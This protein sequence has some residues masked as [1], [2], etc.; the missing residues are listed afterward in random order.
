MISA[1]RAAKGDVLWQ[2]HVTKSGDQQW[3]AVPPPARP[4]PKRSG[5]RGLHRKVQLLRHR[6]C[7]ARI[8]A[9]ASE[10]L[11]L[12]SVNG[13]DR[14]KVVAVLVAGS[15]MLHGRMDQALYAAACQGAAVKWWLLLLRR[16][17]VPR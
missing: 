15:S 7:L 12:N 9:A 13:G 17:S 8:V 2:L 6:L 1:L 5:P 14:P 4:S 16:P 3:L 10:V 11:V